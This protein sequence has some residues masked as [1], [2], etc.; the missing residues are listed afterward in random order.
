LRDFNWI[1]PGR[2]DEIP[3]KGLK[4]GA[5]VRS[6]RPPAPAVLFADGHVAFAE[7]ESGVSPGQACV[8]YDSTDPHARVLGGGF[9]AARPAA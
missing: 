3:H 5:R 8:L 2:L 4:V 9:I 6:T 7:P 1:G